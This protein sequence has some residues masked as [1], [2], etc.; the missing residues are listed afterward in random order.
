MAIRDHSSFGKK[1]GAFDL[2]GTNIKDL[3]K[4]AEKME[5][6]QKSM[7]KKVNERAMGVIEE[8]ATSLPRRHG[9]LIDKQGGEARETAEQDAEHGT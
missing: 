7:K 3:R 1:G 9:A 4:Q 5:A 6:E 8:Y 2:T